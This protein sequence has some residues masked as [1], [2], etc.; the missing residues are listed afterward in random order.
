MESQTD[1]IRE[2]KPLV[3]YILLLF[4][5]VGCSESD[6]MATSV[7]HTN[8]G[9]TPGVQPS[10]TPTNVS[11][12]PTATT[13]DYL[14]GDSLIRD[15]DEMMMVYVPAGTFPMGSS[16]EQIESTMSMCEQYPNQWKKCE[17]DWFE[18]ETPPHVVTVEGFW[19]DSTEVTN[20]QYERCVEA[21]RCQPSRLAN[22]PA[23]NG[24]DYPVAGVPW[25]D[26]VDYCDWVGGRLPTEAEWE[27]AARGAQGY[28]FP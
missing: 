17:R 5:L 14:L 18:V 9:K 20:I 16:E 21:G 10:P 11:P 7:L 12:T 26:A 13:E 1:K 23:Y 27:Y 2:S 28:I 25:L 24:A 6:Q 19:I 22:R 4:L 3:F 15:P 8:A